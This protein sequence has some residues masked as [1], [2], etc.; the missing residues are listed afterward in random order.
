LLQTLLKI[1]RH[2]IEHT[3]KS[4]PD[5]SAYQANLIINM[6]DPQAL[7]SA[8]AEAAGC[9]KVIQSQRCPARE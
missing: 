7:A 5:I 1:V 2:P 3:L 4:C 6:H 8:A 9:Y